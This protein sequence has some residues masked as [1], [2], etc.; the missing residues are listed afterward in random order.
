MADFGGETY[1]PA[2]DGERL[3]KQLG[4]VYA[5][6]ID[7]LWRTLWDVHEITGD[8][9]QSISA[10][11]RDLRKK[12]FGEYIVERRRLGN[13]HRGLWEYR[14]LREPEEDGTWEVEIEIE[15]P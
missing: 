2:Y 1:D 13:P 9:L 8:P 4:R 6:M 11:L 7:G 12:R 14:V 3:T 10:R 15:M 5:A